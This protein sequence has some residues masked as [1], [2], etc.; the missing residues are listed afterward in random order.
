[1]LSSVLAGKFTEF[2]LSTLPEVPERF[3]VTQIGD[4]T[5]T[6]YSLNPELIIKDRRKRNLVVRWNR[7]IHRIAA[8]HKVDQLFVWSPGAENPSDLHSKA[9]KNLPDVLN[10]T[11]WRH[12]HSSY[13]DAVFPS[14]GSTVYAS[15][16]NGQLA[17][18]GLPGSTSH[19]TTCHTCSTEFE[20]GKIVATVLLTNNQ[21]LASQPDQA[22]QPAASP[23][24]PVPRARSGAAGAEG[25]VQLELCESQAEPGY[26]KITAVHRG[27]AVG[28]AAGTA[29]QTGNKNPPEIYKREFYENMTEKF[30]QIESLVNALSILTFWVKCKQ[31]KPISLDTI[32]KQVFCKLMRSSQHYFKP[33][34]IK[35]Q[36]PYLRNGVLVTDNRLNH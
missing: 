22:S 16:A 17:F 20:T 9:H 21:L 26:A 31:K 32:R 13:H 36:L 25:R 35:Q 2:T 19:L 34:N 7:S 12:G 15:M 1:M 5:C 4:S 27:A 3:L 28:G 10:S 18:Y 33:E 23:D 11:F 30:N 6:A 24:K 8:N 29:Q 14:I